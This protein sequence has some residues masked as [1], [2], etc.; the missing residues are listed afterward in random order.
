MSDLAY[1]DQFSTSTPT[2]IN[3]SNYTN[4]CKTSALNIMK[5]NVLGNISLVH[6]RINDSQYDIMKLQARG[7]YTNPTNSTIVQREGQIHLDS[8]TV[9]TKNT[10]NRHS[11]YMGNSSELNETKIKHGDT[12]VTVDHNSIKQNLGVSEWDTVST[13][14]ES[15]VSMVL[16]NTNTIP[17]ITSIIEKQTTTSDSVT[18]YDKVTDTLKS[19][20]AEVK[21]E[22]LN[23]TELQRSSSINLGTNIKLNSS[24]TAD[25]T[26]AELYLESN[27][28][29]TLDATDSIMLK[30]NSVKNDLEINSL[31]HT[32]NTDVHVKQSDFV[33][34]SVT[35][36]VLNYIH[37]DVTLDIDAS[38]HTVEISFDHEKQNGDI[39]SGGTADLESLVRSVTRHFD[40]TTDEVIQN[41]VGEFVDKDFDTTGLKAEAFDNY[42]KKSGGNSSGLFDN[43]AVNFPMEAKQIGPILYV[44]SQRVKA[45]TGGQTPEW[46][47][48]IS[49]LAAELQVQALNGQGGLL[50][51]D[52][53]NS[54][55]KH[56]SLLAAKIDTLTSNF[57]EFDFDILQET[58]LYPTNNYISYKSTTGL[59]GQKV[60]SSIDNGIYYG[61]KGLAL[62]TGGIVPDSTVYSYEN[63][64]T[65]FYYNGDD[66]NGFFQDKIQNNW[67]F[68]KGLQLVS[69]HY[70]NNASENG[71]NAEDMT[72]DYIPDERVFSTHF[73]G[74]TISTETNNYPVKYKLRIEQEGDVVFDPF[75]GIHVKNGIITEAGLIDGVRS[76]TVPAIRLQNYVSWEKDNPNSQD[77]ARDYHFYLKNQAN[78]YNLTN[79]MIFTDEIFEFDEFP[80]YIDFWPK[81]FSLDDTDEDKELNLRDIPIKEIELVGESS[82][83][84]AET[85]PTYNNSTTTIVE[86][87]GLIKEHFETQGIL[88]KVAFADSTVLEA[89]FD[90]QWW[91]DYAGFISAKGSFET[92]V[93][94][95]GREH[96]EVKVSRY[97]N[98]S[99]QAIMI[100]LH[101]YHFEN[102]NNTLKRLDDNTGGNVYYSVTTSGSTINYYTSDGLK[103]NTSD[104]LKRFLQGAIEYNEANV[105]ISEFSVSTDT[106]HTSFVA[107]QPTFQHNLHHDKYVTIEKT[108]YNMHSGS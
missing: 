86:Y 14:N 21:V 3:A 24:S 73:T 59:F 96:I 53:L 23:G 78:D 40:T 94:L 88:P 15:K 98:K 81:F 101:N 90:T 62:S 97:F 36:P 38:D 93:D 105:E 16:D 83:T 12:E 80:R 89:T 75:Y 74:D 71:V 5:D 37:N 63:F 8:D 17:T 67:G 18:L 34:G 6:E 31:G 100:P 57:T 20:S 7:R 91:D 102:T 1:Y 70:D 4:D 64:Q 107:E 2:D 54:L 45:L 22:N 69:Q 85:V 47:D 29:C 9:H 46:L 66:H 87:Y 82:I 13:G 48:S 92:L 41:H 106:A 42:L 27:G 30:A 108:D 51:L 79:E 68:C 49:E 56:V 50:L 33:L 35:T 77:Q 19:N 28:R 55:R 43:N 104:Q 65:Y 95:G 72:D 84:V 103:I 76:F 99:D 26:Q 61:Y 58:L 11:T 44:L 52:E 39:N 25:S 10:F 32:F 60:Y